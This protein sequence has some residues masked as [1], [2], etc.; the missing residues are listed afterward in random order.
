MKVHNLIKASGLVC[1]FLCFNSLPGKTNT[2]Y[3][4]FALGYLAVDSRIILKLIT[5]KRM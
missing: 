2:L 5:K 1:W 4:T 3:Q